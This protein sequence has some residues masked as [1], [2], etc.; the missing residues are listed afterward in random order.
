MC[1]LATCHRSG[2]RRGGVGREIA[3]R[4]TLLLALATIALVG[5]GPTP[6][7]DTRG[8]VVRGS[9][10]QVYVLP[11]ADAKLPGAKMSLLNR[12]GAIVA[13]QAADPLGGVL[14]RHVPAG[15]Y[16]VRLDASGRELGPVTVHSAAAAPWDPAIYNQSIPSSGYT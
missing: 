9:V 10:G 11:G 14:F 7:S 8:L 12:R 4:A 15:S 2:R 13:T 16:K 1:V 5:C 3:G 6:A